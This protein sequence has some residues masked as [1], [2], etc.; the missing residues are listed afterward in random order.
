[1]RRH[2][3]DAVELVHAAVEAAILLG[4]FLLPVWW[5]VPPAVVVLLPM[6]VPWGSPRR[7]WR[8]WLT[9]LEK[10]LRGYPV[11]SMTRRLV[12]AATFRRW[13]PSSKG[14]FVVLALFGAVLAG[15]V[16]EALR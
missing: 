5:V 7:R 1:M 15:R 10:H 13:M 4:V 3:A 8:C 12:Y 14:Q 2:L 11:R 16:L 6:L 9:E